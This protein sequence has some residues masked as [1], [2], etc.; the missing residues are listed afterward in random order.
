MV[1]FRCKKLARRARCAPSPRRGDRAIAFDRAAYPSPAKRGRVAERS[2]AGWGI[3]FARHGAPKKPHPTRLATLGGPPSPCRG[4]ITMPIQLRICD[5]PGRGEGW[6]AG[7][8]TERAI[9]LLRGRLMCRACKSVIGVGE[10]AAYLRGIIGREHPRAMMLEQLPRRRDARG[11]RGERGAEVLARVA[12]A[13]LASVMREHLV[14]KLIDDRPLR[15]QRRRPFAAAAGQRPAGLSGAPGAA[16]PSAP[17][18][19]G[20]GA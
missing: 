13:P 3:K 17:A 4:G 10:M 18:P 16:L 8:R 9:V 7:G 20:V 6:G 15:R 19:H 2:E 14:V 11:R 12:P 5:C 1:R